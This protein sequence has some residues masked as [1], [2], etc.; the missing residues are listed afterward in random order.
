MGYNIWLLSINY[1]SARRSVSR[2]SRLWRS[3]STWRIVAIIPAYGIINYRSVT[4]IVSLNVPDLLLCRF[5]V[6]RNWSAK[7]AKLA[8]IWISSL[9]KFAEQSRQGTEFVIARRKASVASVMAFASF[10][11]FENASAF[12]IQFTKLISKIVHYFKL[13]WMHLI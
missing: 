2:F 9:S 1:D 11:R 5:S 6:A 8:A 3:I 10:Y 12:C 4:T 7:F 13:S